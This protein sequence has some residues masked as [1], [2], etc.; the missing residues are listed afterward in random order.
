M[1]ISITCTTLLLPLAYIGYIEKRLEKSI[2]TQ[3]AAIKDLSQNW[4]HHPWRYLKDT[5][6]W[7]LGM[8]FN[9]G[10]GSAGLAAG[11]DLKGPVQSKRRYNQFALSL[12]KY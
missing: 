10:L 1:L 7:H 12:F 4:R 3:Y 5:Q 6:M 2:G 9:G 11:L 8:W